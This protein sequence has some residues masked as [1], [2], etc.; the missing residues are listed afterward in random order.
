MTL[1]VL[2]RSCYFR[3]R[4]EMKKKFNRKSIRI[5]T[6]VKWKFENI[7]LLSM[8]NDISKLHGASRGF[9]ATAELLVINTPQSYCVYKNVSYFQ[10]LH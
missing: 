5:R 1:N 6:F 3:S 4:H 7:L 2:T 10:Y 8:C 9:S